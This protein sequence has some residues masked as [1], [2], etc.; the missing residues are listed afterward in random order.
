MK[1]RVIVSSAV[2]LLCG[3]L[4]GCSSPD[5]APG[6]PSEEVAAVE[7][8]T[9]EPRDVPTEEPEPSPEPGDL[10]MT[11]PAT[12][13]DGYSMDVEVHSRFLD[14]VVDPSSDKPGE[15]SVIIEATTSISVANTTPSRTLEL[16]SMSGVTYPQDRPFIQ[17]FAVYSADSRACAFD[18][19]IFGKPAEDGRACRI[20]VAYGRILGDFAI[21][22]EEELT[23]YRGF[24][25]QG[26]KP[27]LGMVPEA[28]AEAVR[29]AL[30]APAGFQVEILG[31]GDSYRW[32]SVCDDE[33]PEYGVRASLAVLWS[34]SGTCDD[35]A[36]VVPATGAAD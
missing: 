28:E 21:D 23:V 32:I 9:E 7:E 6:P 17:L 22:G 27:G 4:V 11:I 13:E 12:D 19:D 3:I 1:P 30:E 8:S 14:V 29:A 25:P 35:L 26:F 5:A 16:A 34:T 18:V 36:Y 20:P 15:T 24:L 2:V 31:G 33:E 10:Q